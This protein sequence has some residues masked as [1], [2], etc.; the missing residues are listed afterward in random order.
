MLIFI[1]IFILI[2]IL[3]LINKNISVLE[4]E[5]KL[6]YKTFNDRSLT[7]VLYNIHTR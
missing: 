5:H 1:P 3:I 7:K 6:G 2:L 4:L